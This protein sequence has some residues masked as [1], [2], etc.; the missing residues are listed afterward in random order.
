MSL[1]LYMDENVHGAITN[2]LRQRRVNVLTVQEDHRSGIADPVVL[3][4]ATEL[5]R[6]LFTQDDDLPTEAQRC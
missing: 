3:D 2:G 1:T 5:R 6:I 4:R